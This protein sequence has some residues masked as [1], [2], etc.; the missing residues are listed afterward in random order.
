M[1]GRSQGTTVFG[2]IV[3]SASDDRQEEIATV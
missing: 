2:I 3:V 1:L